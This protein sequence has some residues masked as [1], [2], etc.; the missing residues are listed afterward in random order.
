MLEETIEEY[1]SSI[2]QFLQVLAAV[3]VERFNTMPFEGSWTPGQVAEHII[4][5]LQGV[6]HMLIEAKPVNRAANEKCEAIAGV[7][8]NFDLKFKA[9]PAIMPSNEAKKKEIIMSRLQ[10]VSESFIETIQ[11]YDYTEECTAAE[12]PTLGYLTRLEWMCLASFHIQKH[13]HQLEQMQ[14]N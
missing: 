9:S 1:K 6:P 5:S 10:Q 11:L 7:F 13:T 2:Q 12:V 4:L 3:D 14:L 8:L